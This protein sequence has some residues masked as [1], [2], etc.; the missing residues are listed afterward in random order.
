MTIPPLRE[1]L[2]SGG[3]ETSE[4]LTVDAYDEAIERLLIRAAG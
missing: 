1:R 3:F 4:R 2:R